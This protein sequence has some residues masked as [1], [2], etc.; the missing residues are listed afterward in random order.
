VVANDHGGSR[1]T[2]TA[3]SA[4]VAQAVVKEIGSF[5]G[6]AIA[7]TTAVGTP[8]AADVIVGKAMDAF[9][10]VDILVNNA[11]GGLGIV[12][13]D[14]GTDDQVEGIIRTNLLGPYMLTRRVWP[15]MR[16]QKYGRIVYLM[17]G[18]LV[19]MVGT[20][21]YSAAKAGL[22]GLNNTVAI[23]G[24]PLGIS[25][26]G[27]WPVAYTRLAGDLKDPQLHEYMKQFKATL[28]AEGIIYLASREN[29]ATGE[30]FTLG[31]GAVSRNALFG[32]SGIA[33]L[34][35]TAEKLAE[36]SDK[37]RDLSDAALLQ[38]SVVHNEDKTI[39]EREGAQ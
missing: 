24:G 31:G 36:N 30:M 23:E 4:D 26:N 38:P 5:G 33:D 27:V 25:S 37:A 34:E 28:V 18:T 16:A 17:S 11:G 20:G 22:I 10:R 6:R 12:E 19:G 9:G 21:P 29:A 14:Q 2:L 32:N 7:D 35:L 3:G 1:D 15:I 13:I 8:S 39:L